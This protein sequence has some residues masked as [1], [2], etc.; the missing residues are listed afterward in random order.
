[1][2]K[3]I[4]ILLVTI[5]LL[6]GTAPAYADVT[7]SINGKSY[8]PLTPANL[9]NGVTM[10]GLD[11][12]SRVMG[13]TVLIE[14]DLYVLSKNNIKL[15]LIV[16]QNTAKLNGKTYNLAA[17]PKIVAG[18]VM[19]PLRSVMEALG[20]E[21]EWQPQTRTVTVTYLETR[22]D[23]T[24]E[25][26]MLKSN[27]VLTEHN[28]YKIKAELIE[29]ADPGIPDQSLKQFRVLDLAVQRNPVL[30]H[31]KTSVQIEDLSP[32]PE[33]SSSEPIINEHVITD[34][35]EF[36]T[37]PKFE[38]WVK[39]TSEKDNQALLE[40]F[41]QFYEP[42]KEIES[43]CD[44]GAI[45]SFADDCTIDRQECWTVRVV[46][47]D[48]REQFN[49]KQQTASE[50]IRCTSVVYDVYINQSSFELLSIKL[51][52][53]SLSLLPETGIRTKMETTG[54]YYI[55]DLNQPVTV[56]NVSNYI[57]MDDYLQ[58]IL[59]PEVPNDQ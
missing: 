19:V 22:K 9:E 30:A 50:Y 32:H 8:S 21:V 5:F 4:L 10:I 46:R 49:D 52:G 40:A 15:D 59:R 41:L 27:Q 53:T 7:L 12:V 3:R 23:M 20:A 2:H 35:G 57:S 54:Y 25:E 51:E 13:G 28:T 45:I 48:G 34:E 6:I 18:E 14:S 1:M 11:N 29:K 33:T 37:V 26:V 17:A 47:E 39:S 58:N 44:A 24:P 43:V 16:G 56:P 55:Y 38:V 36:Y 42:M 31:A